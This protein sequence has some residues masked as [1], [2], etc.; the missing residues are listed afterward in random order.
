MTILRAEF[1]PIASKILDDLHSLRVNLCQDVDLEAFS[2]PKFGTRIP[3][4]LFSLR[5]LWM[6]RAH[7]RKFILI[8]YLLQRCQ[9]RSYLLILL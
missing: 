3:G 1:K 2:F 6:I 5:S 4:G 9:F 8:R 7:Y